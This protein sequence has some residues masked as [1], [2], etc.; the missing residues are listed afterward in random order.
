[1]ENL[2]AKKVRPDE[3]RGHILDIAHAAFIR[4]GYAGTSM[5]RIAALLGGSKTTL[6]NYFESKKELFVAVADRECAKLFDQIFVASEIAGDFRDRVLELARRLLDTMLAD[7]MIAAYRLIVAESGRFPEIGLAMHDI[8]LRRG[9]QHLAVF[10]KRAMEAGEMR[11]V[12]PK[13]AAE[14]FLDLASGTLH[15]IRLWNVVPAIE[16]ERMAQEA[17]RIAATFLAAFG[18]DE[19]SRQARRYSGY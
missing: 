8:A 6:Y 18:N 19:L 17:E 5:S 1:M 10:F 15:K 3:R 14:Q 11:E 4:E 13:M 2:D 7:D 16:P 12:N 9:T